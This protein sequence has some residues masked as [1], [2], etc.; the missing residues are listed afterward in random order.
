LRYF[1]LLTNGSALARKGSPRGSFR[2]TYLNQP[3]VK[4]ALSAIIAALYATV[5]ILFAPISFGPFQ[6]R[7]ADALMPLA[8]IF[9][10]VAAAG[11]SLGCVV[12]NFFGFVMGATP[13]PFDILGGAVANLIASVLAYNIY[14]ALTSKGRSAFAWTQ[15]PILVEN[16]V[17]TFIVGSYLA[18]LYPMGIDFA[19]S[20]TLWYIGIF[21]GSLI[22]MNGIGYLIYRMSYS[23][24]A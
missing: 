12:A 10:Y 7:V 20:A 1:K 22:T 5:V 16:V 2:D 6:V 13:T 11:L 19:S 15:I 9:G 14:R 24:L 23:A 17:V 18:I 4:V 8:L 3:N 21:L